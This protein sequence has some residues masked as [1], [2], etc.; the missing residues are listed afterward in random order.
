MLEQGKDDIKY[1]FLIDQDGV[2]YEGRGWDFV[3]QHT[4]GYD[5]KSLGKFIPDCL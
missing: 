1:N 2:I 3:G 4:D 5:M